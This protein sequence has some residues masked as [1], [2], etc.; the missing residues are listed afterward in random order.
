ML[1]ESLWGALNMLCSPATAPF[2]LQVPRRVDMFQAIDGTYPGPAWVCPASRARTLP[3]KAMFSNCKCWPSSLVSN[4]LLKVMAGPAVLTMLPPLYP[5]PVPPNTVCPVLSLISPPAGSVR[6]PLASNLNC[7]S[8][9]QMLTSP[10][11]VPKLIPPVTGAICAPL[12]STFGNFNAP[13]LPKFH[14]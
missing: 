6:T 10:V 3:T 12:V 9:G 1:P 7:L 8:P 5:P 2:A 4:I 13:S 11:S 14:L